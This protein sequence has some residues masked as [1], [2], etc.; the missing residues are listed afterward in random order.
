MG[1]GAS[2]SGLKAMVRS[3][4]K[5]GSLSIQQVQ[6][7]VDK[8]KDIKS[9]LKSKL[10]NVDFDNLNAKDVDY[11]LDELDDD[12]IRQIQNR[13]AGIGY[14]APSIMGGRRNKSRR[15]KRR[16]GKSRRTYRHISKCGR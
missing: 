6:A 16:N 12:F 7:F 2:T 9:A 8:E 15:K 14:N 5:N 3:G 4:L 11:L 10:S 13:M 1:A